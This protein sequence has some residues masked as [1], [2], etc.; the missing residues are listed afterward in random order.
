MNLIGFGLTLHDSSIAAYKDGKFLYRKAERQFNSKHAHGNIEWALSVLKEWDIQEYES[1][2]STWLTGKNP[3]KIKEGNKLDH[4]YSHILSASTIKPEN[5]CLDFGAF[6]P[7]DNEKQKEFYSGMIKVSN[8]QVERYNEYPVP[9]ILNSLMLGKFFDQETK[10]RQFLIDVF[11]NQG[12]DDFANKVLETGKEPKDWEN[13][14]GCIDFPNKVM[15]LQSKGKPNREQINEWMKQKQRNLAVILQSHHTLP[16]DITADYIATVHKFCEETVLQKT[17]YPT[18]NYTGGVAQNVV[19]NRAMLDIGVVPSI[20]PWAY[21]GGCSI[22]ALNYLLDKH[23]IERYADWVQDDESPVD[24]PGIYTLVEIS[25]L[26]AEGKVVGWYQGNGEVGPRALGN[27]SILYDPSRKDAKDKVNKI[28]Q[29]EWWR[30]F[31]ASVL[32]SKASQFFDLPESRHMLFNSNVLYSGIP[33]VTH[34]D[35]TCRHQTVPDNDT[36]LQWLLTYFE[37]ETGLPVLLNTSLNVKGKPL[38]S[39]IEQAI[40]LFKTTEMDALC[41][42]DTVYK[43]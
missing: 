19:F 27:R 39:T 7:A 22:G 26:L 13:F 29:R 34:V 6:G 3:Q 4:H 21:D 14:V 15:A 32:E 23:N 30:P 1:A 18:F 25:Q 17:T 5:I 31:G 42:G 2:E 8:R 41:V 11:V 10:A 40:Q 9:G 37:L 36:P 38:C 33:G 12:F 35:G 20:D 28:K 24:E 16:E 43:K